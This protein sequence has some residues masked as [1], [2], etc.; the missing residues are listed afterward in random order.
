MYYG[1]KLN[2]IQ[3]ENLLE[4]LLVPVKMPS[5]NENGFSSFPLYLIINKDFFCV[6]FMKHKKIW[7]EEGEQI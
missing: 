6:L 3:F 7:D 4:Y 5:L 1:D 2:C